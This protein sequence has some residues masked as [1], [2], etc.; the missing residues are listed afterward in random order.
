[1]QENVLNCTYFTLAIPLLKVFGMLI[2]QIQQALL[3]KSNKQA[4][5]EYPSVCIAGEKE[6]RKLDT[7][8]GHKIRAREGGGWTVQHSTMF[9]ESQVHDECVAIYKLDFLCRVQTDKSKND[10]FCIHLYTVIMDPSHFIF[11][12]TVLKPPI[13]NLICGFLQFIFLLLSFLPS[14]NVINGY[15]N[16]N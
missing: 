6:T 15:W 5:I 4:L 12:E 16:T 14:M 3:Y 7:E 13:C 10:I 9:V 1:M 11:I 2:H 8:R